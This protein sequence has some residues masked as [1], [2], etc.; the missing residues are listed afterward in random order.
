M[1]VIFGQFVAVSF[2]ILSLV[3]TLPDPPIARLVIAG[4]L[5]TI[6]SG[7]LFMPFSKTLWA[8]IDLTM[9]STMGP[10]YETSNAQP[11]LRAKPPVRSLNRTPE[12]PADETFG[13]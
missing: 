1:N 3:W 9:H 2:L 11:G 12:D 4:A 13:E 5:I 6:V 7:L 8:A 10:S